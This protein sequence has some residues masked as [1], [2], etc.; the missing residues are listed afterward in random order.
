MANHLPDAGLYGWRTCRAFQATE[1]EE[2]PPRGSAEA[3]RLEGAERK[4]RRFARAKRDEANREHF[5]D[6]FEM[7]EEEPEQGDDE[8]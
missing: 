8:W 4:A 2:R 1:R 7:P 5:G 3:A 6:D